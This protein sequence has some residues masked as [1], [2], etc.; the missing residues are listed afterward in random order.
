MKKVTEGKNSN[1]VLVGKLGLREM[2]REYL[3]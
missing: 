2:F 1:I 3:L